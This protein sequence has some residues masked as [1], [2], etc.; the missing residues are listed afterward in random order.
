[1]KKLTREEIREQEELNRI[2][3]D[4]DEGKCIT[5]NL[6]EFLEEMKKW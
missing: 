5:L 3:K 1:M 2:W 4:I 6:G